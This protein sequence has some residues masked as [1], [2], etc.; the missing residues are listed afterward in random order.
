MTNII[1]NL[2]QRSGTTLGLVEIIISLIISV[3]VLIIFIFIFINFI[4]SKKQTKL[5]VEKKSIV[6]TGTMILFFIA[7]YFI[8]K[9]KF[10]ELELNNVPL[11]ISLVITGLVIIILGCFVNIKGRLDLG[12][13]WANQIKI[14]EN[15]TLI[16]DG[17]YKIVRHPLYASLIWMFYGASIVYLNFFAFLANTLVFIPFM[18]YRAKQEEELLMK[19]FKNYKYYKLKVGMFFPKI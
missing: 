1:Q 5:R 10:G 8:L 17:V 14:Y 3:C 16:T 9:F 18:Y 4:E 19:Y 7:F 6:E 12:K 15:H 11:K 13:N 2:I